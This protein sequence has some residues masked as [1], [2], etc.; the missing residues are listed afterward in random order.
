MPGPTT[1]E[2]VGTDPRPG[3]A[4][5]RRGVRPVTTPGAPYLTGPIR[6][7][8]STARDVRPRRDRRP[9]PTITAGIPTGTPAPVSASHTTPCACSDPGL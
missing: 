4:R 5:R 8:H 2:P 9:T 3:P 1:P 7:D 6:R